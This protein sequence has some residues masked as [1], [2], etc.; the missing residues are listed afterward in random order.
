MEDVTLD[1][2]Q[3]S[4]AG[5]STAAPHSQAG[6]NVQWRAGSAH[7]AAA[8]ALADDVDDGSDHGVPELRRSADGR[9]ADATSRGQRCV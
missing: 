4:G 9:A 6:D 8:A 5:P 1:D 2:D 3:A 7:H